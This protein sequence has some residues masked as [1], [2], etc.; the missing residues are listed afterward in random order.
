MNKNQIKYIREQ[1]EDQNRNYWKTVNLTEFLTKKNIKLDNHEL[2][3]LTIYLIK[4]DVFRFIDFLC[5]AIQDLAID[6]ENFVKIIELV[7]DKTNK[8]MIF[9]QFIESL[10]SIGKSNPQLAIKIANKLL[11]SKN[12]EYS[13]YL[14]AG[15]SHKMEKECSILVTKLLSTE[16]SGYQ[17]AALRTLRIIYNEFK[18]CDAQQIFVIL[19]QFSRSD[20]IDVKVETMMALLSFYEKDTKKS[21]IIIE[22]LARDNIECTS[23]LAYR[24]SIQYS[25]FDE[26]T[27][28]YF[29]EICSE[30]SDIRVKQHV[31]YAL[32]R[33]VQYPDWILA[34]IVKY[35]IQDKF[36]GGI[37]YVLEE[38]GK[39]NAAKAIVIILN[40]FKKNDNPILIDFLPLIIKYLVSKIDKKI[41]LEPV[42]QMIE[43]EPRFENTGINILLEIVSDMYEGCHDPKFTSSLFDFLKN[44]A[45][46]KGINVGSVISGESNEIMRCADLI[47]HIRYNS[48][49]LD[50]DI[51]FQNL[52]K[53]PN[54]RDMFGSFWFEQQ[55]KKKNRTH[56][57]LKKL[58]QKLPSRKRYDELSSVVKNVKNSTKIPNSEFQL[59]AMK[60][61]TFLYKLDQNIGVLKNYTPPK[62]YSKNYTPPKAYS[63][64]LKNEPQFYDTVS[65]INFIVPFLSD[66]C[67]KFEPEINSKKLDAKIE[68]GEQSI[69]VEITRPKMFKPLAKLRGSIYVSNKI[70]DKIYDKFKFQLKD[71]GSTDHA[72][73][74]AIDMQQSVLDYHF[75]TDYLLG[76]L[77]YTI[78]V[79]KETGKIVDKLPSRDEKKSMH[80]LNSST[81]LISAIVC[82]ETQIRDDLSY[83]TKVSIY[84]NKHA[85][86]PLD[87]TTKKVIQKTLDFMHN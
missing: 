39:V 64:N 9:G 27:C 8:D 24:I 36:M 77:Q 41:I 5:R 55:R 63:K 85:R 50:Y 37:D 21:K 14:I 78:W 18:K 40:W 12:P 34:I 45:E 53:F 16:N 80:E 57:I 84:E 60:I 49:P 22:R 86:I 20:F 32:V 56:P 33:F 11:N 29:L 65:E 79:D 81:C 13:S 59:K 52:D 30:Y 46:N 58:G 76:P 23:L 51:I 67:V 66:Y 6:I 19:E 7:I 44:M 42:F 17:I 4:E 28:M 54:I 25:P 10:I 69:Y 1:I 3:E 15:A 75:V 31:L 47:D 61:M 73:I 26:K 70:K 2:C 38:L 82:Y 68:I 83:I 48:K 62:A 35:V 87:D 74:I 43:S 71:L 72:V